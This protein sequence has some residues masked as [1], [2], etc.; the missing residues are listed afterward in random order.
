V[1]LNKSFEF[2]VGPCIYPNHDWKVL[3]VKD[4]NNE[5]FTLPQ[6]LS[7]AVLFSI[8]EEKNLS[9]RKYKVF[10]AVAYEGEMV[11]KENEG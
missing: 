9:K 6:G 3:E 8:I 11:T 1:A 7:K 2:V 5:N 10:W 4:S